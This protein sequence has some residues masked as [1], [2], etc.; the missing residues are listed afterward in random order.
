MG[1]QRGPPAAALREA[2]GDHKQAVMICPT[3]RKVQAKKV[4]VEPLMGDWNGRLGA[5]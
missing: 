2:G 4:P 3:P 1:R 5:V